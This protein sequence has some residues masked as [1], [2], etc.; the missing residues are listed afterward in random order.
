LARRSRALR[1]WVASSGEFVVD[2]RITLVD[3]DRPGETL[4]VDVIASDEA[5]LQLQVP[6]TSVQ[7]RL[8]RRDRTTAYEGS[9][10]GRYFY[11]VPPRV[12][13]DKKDAR[14]GAQ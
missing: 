7:F 10:G 13:V 5:V 3:V 11:F 6:N 1:N 4:E 12:R 9:L 14:S 2:K 8:F